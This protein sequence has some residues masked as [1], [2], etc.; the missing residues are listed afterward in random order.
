MHFSM[1]FRCFFKFFFMAFAGPG[2]QGGLDLPAVQR[3][4]LG[5]CAAHR[6]A[7]ADPWPTPVEARVEAFRLS[8]RPRM[9]LLG[10]KFDIGPLSFYQAPLMKPP[11]S[12]YDMR[13]TAAPARCSTARP[14]SGSRPRRRPSCWTSAAAWAPLGSARAGGVGRCWA[15]SW[16]R[17]RWNRPRPTPPGAL[18]VR[19]P[20]LFHPFS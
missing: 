16:C 12:T 14:W 8:K 13:R 9:E 4:G 20:R 6:G 11:R 15:S 1:I 5:R 7:C 17:R 19:I 3:R 18:K 10:L 2:A